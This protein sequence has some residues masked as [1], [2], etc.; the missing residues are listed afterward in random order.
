MFFRYG[1]YIHPANEVALTIRKEARYS[2]RG[3]KRSVVETWNLQGVLQAATPA[4]LSGRI[5]AL[6]AA[7][8]AN[9]QTAALCFDDGSFTAHVLDTIT[10]LGG[11]RVVSLD[12]PEGRGAEYS[13]FR[14]YQLVLAAEYATPGEMLLEYEESIRLEGGGPKFVILQTLTGV[15][16]RQQVAQITP[17]RAVQTGRALGLASYPPVSTPLWPEA[18]HREQRRVTFHSPKFT[19]HQFSEFAVEWEFH[20]EAANAL[21]GAPAPR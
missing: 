2:D 7:Y 13:T 17:H 20:F 6:T 1:K 21:L 5:A 9:G 12:F 19:N 16:Q 15:P 14:T 3:Q 11:V 4:E 8:A 18:E 10:S